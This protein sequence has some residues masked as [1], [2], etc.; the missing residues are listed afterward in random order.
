MFS[1]DLSHSSNFS[2]M[3]AWTHKLTKHVFGHNSK[4]KM[5][6]IIVMFNRDI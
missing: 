6:L 4:M 2:Q 1:G 3:S 5:Y